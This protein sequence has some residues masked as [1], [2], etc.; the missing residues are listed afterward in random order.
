MARTQATPIPYDLR[1]QLAMA[2]E[3][4]AEK[5]REQKAR[6]ILT[7]AEVARLHGKVHE[8]AVTAVRRLADDLDLHRLAHEEPT[9]GDCRSLLMVCDAVDVARTQLRFG[10]PPLTDSMGNM[11]T[12]TK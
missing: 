12:P 10:L 8:E 11:L 9:L 5:A 2:K 1:D 3:D 6:K 7:A 4:E